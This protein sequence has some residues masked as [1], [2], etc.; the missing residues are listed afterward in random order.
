MRL[1]I[2]SASQLGQIYLLELACNKLIIKLPE[3][4]LGRGSSVEWVV[5]SRK[6]GACPYVTYCRFPEDG[7]TEKKPPGMGDSHGAT[8]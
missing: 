7:C 1:L 3:P 8:E 2:S 4:G 5:A 6:W